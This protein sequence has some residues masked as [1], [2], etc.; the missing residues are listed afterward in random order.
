MV[1]LN[2]MSGNSVG[3]E[4]LQWV[5]DPSFT[6]C[7]FVCSLILELPILIPCTDF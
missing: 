6:Y 2:Q 4:K 3:T 5:I 1:P 7:I